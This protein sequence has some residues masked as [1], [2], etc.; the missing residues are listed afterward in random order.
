M[1]PTGAS[2]YDARQT[3]NVAPYLK[4]GSSASTSSAP[5]SGST[6]DSRPIQLV[7]REGGRVLA[8]VLGD[9]VDA[10]LANA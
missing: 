4:G 2:V 7:L 10:T 6:R 5:A 1:L 8:D 9:H 3:A